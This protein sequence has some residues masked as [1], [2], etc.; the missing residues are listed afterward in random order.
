MRHTLCVNGHAYGAEVGNLRYL[1]F[2]W[3]FI[4]QICMPVT[5][6]LKGFLGVY[7]SGNTAAAGVSHVRVRGDLMSVIIIKC[8]VIVVVYKLKVFDL[9]FVGF[10]A[11]FFVFWLS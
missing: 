10:N 6:G 11:L 1:V 3:G 2:N 5:G 4:M 9:S 8:F 7:V